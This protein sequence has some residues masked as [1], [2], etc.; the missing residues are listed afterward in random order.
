MTT[1]WRRF[2]LRW[3]RTSAAASWTTRAPA[4]TSCRATSTTAASPTQSSSSPSTGTRDMLWF[5]FCVYF[6]PKLTT[7]VIVTVPV[8]L[9]K[10]RVGRQRQ[11]ADR[12]GRADRHQ[13][14]RRERRREEQTF[15]V[16]ARLGSPKEYFPGCENALGKFRKKW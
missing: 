10:P 12:P 15:Q 13:L 3:R 2:T 4:S 8:K 16:R 14:S 6:S 9:Q 11:D 7:Y 1:L 5:P